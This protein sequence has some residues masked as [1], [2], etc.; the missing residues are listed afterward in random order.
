MRGKF[1]NGD[2]ERKW[3]QGRET[4]ILGEEENSCCPQ[5]KNVVQ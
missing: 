4:R 1:C 5:G 2:A 3:L